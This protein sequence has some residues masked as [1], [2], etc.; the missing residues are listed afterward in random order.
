MWIVK[1]VYAFGIVLWELLTRQHPFEAERFE[2][3]S[4][5]KIFFLI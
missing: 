3:M 1:D 2:F 4:Q 5:V